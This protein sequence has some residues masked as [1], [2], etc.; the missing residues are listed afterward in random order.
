M[1][2]WQR[3]NPD[4][5]AEMVKK[6]VEVVMR[7]NGE[8]IAARFYFSVDINES[9]ITLKVW[10]SEECTVVLLE[11]VPFADEDFCGKCAGIISTVG[12]FVITGGDAECLI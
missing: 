6:I 3:L 8:D 12:T 4:V 7:A 11:C 1:N 9:E 10:D 2:Y 5:R